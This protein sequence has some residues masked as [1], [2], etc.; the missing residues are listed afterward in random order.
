MQW[1]S[2]GTVVV[3]A[4]IGKDGTVNNPQV[5][6]GPQ[7]F[8]HA[9]LD[10]VARW[11]YKPAQSN[12]EP[13]E[14]P[15]QIA[16]DFHPPGEATTAAA[17]LELSSGSGLLP[18]GNANTAKQPL[19]ASVLIPAQLVHSVPPVYPAVA[20]QWQSRGTVVVKAK[21]GKD[22][23]V[24]SPLVVSGPQIF[25]RA[26]LDA[27]EQW[28]YKPALSNGEAV[29]Q[30]IEIPL[31]FY[32]SA[33]SAVANTPQ[34]S[35]GGASTVALGDSPSS[36]ATPPAI[37]ANVT[38][39]PAPVQ[40]NVI[41]AQLIHSVPPAYPAVA[42]QWLS[43]GTVVVKAKIGKDGK[44][45]NPLVVSGPQVFHRAALDALEQWR[46]KPALSNGEAVEQQ[47]EI[48]LSF[49]P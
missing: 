31:D 42:R 26:A 28:R 47:I 17:H 33:E 34:Q 4:K 8:Q 19:P 38:K 39:Q 44:V 10:A 22:G 1:R 13:I 21:I 30:Q 29:E 6:S 3:K 2:S 27:L 18:V 20:R 46:Y 24:N 25:H 32:P 43:S 37:S 9:A 49:H 15:I 40:A 41:P 16:L 11:R 5:V 23:K 12:G 48:P 36:T 14:Q 45:N 7:I 35:S